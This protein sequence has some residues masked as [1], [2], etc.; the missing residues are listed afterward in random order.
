MWPS[1]PLKYKFLALSPFSIPSIPIKLCPNSQGKNSSGENGCSLEVVL[2]LDSKSWNIQRI[3]GLRCCERDQKKRLG[4]DIHSGEWKARSWEAVS[5][6]NSND[7][8]WLGNTITQKGRKPQ[9]EAGAC[10]LVGLAVAWHASHVSGRAEHS[11]KL[12]VTG[13]QERD[14]AVSAVTSVDQD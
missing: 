6:K 1:D 14:D 8:V 5:S 13:R 3:L 7:R 12:N 10:R 4:R 9:R 11:R 2:F